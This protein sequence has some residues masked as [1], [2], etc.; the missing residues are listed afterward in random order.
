MFAALGERIDGV[1]IAAEAPRM[2]PK[3]EF[4]RSLGRNVPSLWERPVGLTPEEAVE[5]SDL[6]EGEAGAGR[7]VTFNRFGMASIARDLLSSGELELGEV[8]GFSGA[9]S[10]SIPAPDEKPW[11][12]EHR[13]PAPIHL[14]D[15]VWDTL[16]FLGLPRVERVTAA[17][18]E[19]VEGAH[20]FDQTWSLIAELEG[21]VVGALQALQYRSTQE[22]GLSVNHLT[23]SGTRS[24]I[25]LQGGRLR[26]I[27][28]DGMQRTWSPDDLEI[29][30]ALESS[31]SALESFIVREQGYPDGDPATL[32]AAKALA[33]ADWAWIRELRGASAEGDA[34][35]LGMVTEAGVTIIPGVAAVESARTGQPVRV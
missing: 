31:V 20:R 11:R 9:T 24:T 33:L 6:E 19:G 3:A 12:W 5:K 15:Q 22:F 18:R 1:V 13:C 23:I 26:V 4:L 17:M 25:E 27:T 10:L 28:A 8:L 16:Y 30:P 2:R 34:N 21:G 29:P 14:L 7:I 35:M 32:A